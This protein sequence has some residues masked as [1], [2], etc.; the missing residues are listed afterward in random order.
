MAT[1][2]FI[3]GRSILVIEDD[4]LVAEILVQMLEDA[5]STVL[6]PIGWRDEALT[7]ISRNSATFDTAVLDVNLHGQP[8]YPIADAL[9]ERGIKFIF[10]TGYGADALATAYRGYPRCEK[11]FQQQTLFAALT[12]VLI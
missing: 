6:G 12:S 7:F 10:T 8:S 4:Y 1:A 11:P 2:D 5:G 9:I 3:Q